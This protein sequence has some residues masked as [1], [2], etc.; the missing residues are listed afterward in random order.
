MQAS[1][2]TR[3]KLIMPPAAPLSRVEISSQVGGTNTVSS[4]QVAD[5]EIHRRVPS[6]FLAEFKTRYADILNIQRFPVIFSDG[7]NSFMFD[8]RNDRRDRNI[9]ALV[10]RWNLLQIWCPGS[11]KNVSVF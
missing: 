4:T 10:W 2:I 5:I 11:L 7:A 3:T 1:L 8:R 6:W 9:S